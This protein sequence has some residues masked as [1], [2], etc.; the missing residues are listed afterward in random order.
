MTGPQAAPGLFGYGDI[1][2]NGLTDLVVSGDGDSRVF[3]YQQ[4]N[5]GNFV[6]HVLDGI[7]GEPLMQS[8]FGQ[9]GGMKIVDLD[10][11]GYNE[12][13]VTSYEDNKIY[14]YKVKR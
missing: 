6:Q 2:G 7:E 4:T 12:I 11:D 3:W 14:I 13:L 8:K 5:P 1:T 9:A 10:N